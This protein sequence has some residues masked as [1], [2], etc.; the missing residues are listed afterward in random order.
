MASHFGH[1]RGARICV[2]AALAF[3]VACSHASQSENAT[4]S[5]DLSLT[6]GTTFDK[7]EILDL[8]SFTDTQIERDTLQCFLEHTPYSH[9]SF[10]STYV[11]N[12]IR[13]SDALIGV[14]AK[15]GINPFVLLVRLE[16]TQGLVEQAGYPAPS[17]RVEYVFR[18]GC[19]SA[20]QC[21]PSLAGLDK[22][23]DCLA[24]EL[25]A[26]VDEVKANGMTPGGWGTRQAATTLDGEQVMP[27]DE[28]TAALYQYEPI[29]GTGKRGNWLFW[30]VWQKYAAALGRC[31]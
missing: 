28:S 5:Q 4:P 3:V 15:Y 18:C 2:L 9:P 10:L 25:R 8:A 21:D 30:N 29:V 16:V 17:S 12:G 26:S 20:D 1:L 24:R 27:K 11:S 23:L 6:D 7:N 31:P 22:Q 13:A 19:V 14:G